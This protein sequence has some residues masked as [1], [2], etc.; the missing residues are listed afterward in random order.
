MAVVPLLKVAGPEANVPLPNPTVEG[1][2]GFVS[3]PRGV[4]EGLPGGGDTGANGDA[5]EALKA[6][7]PDAANAEVDV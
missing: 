4:N 2:R 3:D 7:K 5:V 1:L 6:P